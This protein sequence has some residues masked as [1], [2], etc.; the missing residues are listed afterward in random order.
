M[1]APSEELGLIASGDR[2]KRILSVGV[3]EPAKLLGKDHTF[4]FLRFIQR[5]ENQPMMEF[6]EVEFFMTDAEA[7][8]VADSELFAD[9]AARK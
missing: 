3:Q 2:V 6:A 4:V 8:R 9:N 5:A 7:F 1:K